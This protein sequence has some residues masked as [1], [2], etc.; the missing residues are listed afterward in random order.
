MKA[1]QAL[2]MRGP[3]V[4]RYRS[5]PRRPT[6][7]LGSTQS[8]LPFETPLDKV[9]EIVAAGLRGIMGGTR[10]IYWQHDEEAIPVAVATASRNVHRRR[11]QSP[12]RARSKA[13][14]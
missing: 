13:S 3:D 11:P 4:Q 7:S 1:D 14:T 5:K 2:L 6:W 12:S 10:P 9:D 8:V